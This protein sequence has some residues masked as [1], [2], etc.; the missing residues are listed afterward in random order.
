MKN[1]LIIGA[2]PEITGVIN[3][4]VNGFEGFKGESITSI[5]ELEAKLNKTP[6]DILLMGAGFNE[7]EEHQIRKT[8]AAFLPDIKIVEH[9]GGGSGL[10]LEELHRE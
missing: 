8:A 10:L 7:D 1:V 5:D 9:Y 4:L 2:D 3:R 6:F